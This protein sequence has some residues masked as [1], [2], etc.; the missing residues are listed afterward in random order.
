[1]GLFSFIRIWWL[2]SI[3][4]TIHPART[5]AAICFSPPARGSLGIRDTGSI[6]VNTHVGGERGDVDLFGRGLKTRLDAPDDGFVDIPDGL[7]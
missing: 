1:M 7:I 4:F 3:W 2:P 6:D 5:N